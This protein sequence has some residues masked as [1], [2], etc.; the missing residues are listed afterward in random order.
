VRFDCL[1]VRNH[2]FIYCDAFTGWLSEFADF[3]I[4]SMIF[5]AINKVMLN[6]FT[7]ARVCIAGSVRELVGIEVDGQKILRA[8]VIIETS[9]RT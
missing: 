5:L 8:L 1:Y 4:D 7:S 3:R 9:A 2:R 6:G